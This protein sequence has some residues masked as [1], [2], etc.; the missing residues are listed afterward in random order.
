MRK[1]IGTHC[2]EISLLWRRWAGCSQSSFSLMNLC[3]CLS[4]HISYRWSSLILIRWR[5]CSHKPRRRRRCG[6]VYHTKQAKMNQEST[7]DD[8][9][10]PMSS[11]LSQ[12]CCTMST[13]IC[14]ANWAVFCGWQD[15]LGTDQYIA[16]EA[17]SKLMNTGTKLHQQNSHAAKASD[18]MP[19]TPTF[20]LS[21]GIWRE[22]LRCF[23]YL[24]CGSDWIPV[25][26]Q[27]GLQNN[28][29]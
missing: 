27:G 5:Q 14:D 4:L 20:A 10:L 23:G 7:E 22:L 29:R 17:R 28:S 15:V 21:K 11:N 16:Q 24:C 25:R 19:V 26:C 1:Q 3:P 8:T 9:W 13:P 12:T 2:Q 18:F 6:S